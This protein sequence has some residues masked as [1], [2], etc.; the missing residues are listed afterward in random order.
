[1]MMINDDDDLSFPLVTETLEKE[2]L[3]ITRKMTIALANTR[4]L[5]RAEPPTLAID[6]DGS[7][8]VHG[9]AE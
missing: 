8:R 4:W 3:L 6:E 5:R 1:M 9:V 2:S 7:Q